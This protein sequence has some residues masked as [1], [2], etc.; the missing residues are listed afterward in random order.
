MVAITTGWQNPDV[1]IKLAKTS[2]SRIRFARLRSP[3]TDPLLF[4]RIFPYP[5]TA[6]VRIIPGK[7]TPARNCLH[8]KF[9]RFWLRDSAPANRPNGSAGFA[10]FGA[11]AVVLNHDSASDPTH[12]TLPAAPN[13]ES[14]MRPRKRRCV[15]R[16]G[17][18]AS[19]TL[20]GG[21]RARRENFQSY[22]PAKAT[23][24]GGKSAPH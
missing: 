12:K 7:C 10:S 22:S 11:A 13:R 19:K 5:S 24:T 17:A 23:R 14:A 16:L 20:K 21:E 9:R 6:S 3:Q 4:I 2:N 1:P 8:E 18:L 15:E